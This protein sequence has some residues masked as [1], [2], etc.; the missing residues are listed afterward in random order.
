MLF[1]VFQLG[2]DRYAVEANRVV[3]VLPLLEIKRIPQAPKGIAG[4]FNLRGQPVPA[5]D[6]NELTFGHAAR[7]RLTTRIILLRHADAEGQPRL[8]G[9]IAECV[10]Q[11][12]R[13]RPSD[14]V[15][16]GL[17]LSSA[18]YL[19]PVLMDSPVPIQWLHAEHLVSEPIRQ[20]LASELIM[21]SGTPA[22]I[23]SGRGTQS[24]PL[25]PSADPRVGL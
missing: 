25:K 17:T 23:S 2:K 1:L 20:L 14:F 6:L 24:G 22:E 8:L 5:L 16:P 12:I 3:E 18:P 15:N 13:K 21:A 4:I 10:T 11:T 19:G 9:L 7:Q